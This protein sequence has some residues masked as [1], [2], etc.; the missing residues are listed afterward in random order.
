[1]PLFLR[2][3]E[4]SSLKGSPR[5]YWIFFLL[6][7]LL[8]SACSVKESERHHPS[9]INTTFDFKGKEFDRYVS[10]A[11][12][13]IE[14]SRT[15]FTPENREVIINGNAP[16]SLVPSKECKPGKDHPYTRGILLIHGLSDSPYSM[17]SLARFFKR[18]CFFVEVLLLP[19]H[20][21]R[22]GDL[23]DVTWEEWAKAVSFA[24]G[25]LEK[26]AERI[27]LGGLSTGAALSIHHAMKD[28][29]IEGLFLFSPAVKITPLARA[30]CWFAGL[31]RVIPS[32]RWIGKLQRDDNYF[33]YQSFSA[34]A[35]C[36]IFRL[37]K[38]IEKSLS[39]SPLEIPLFVAASADDST[40]KFEG[41]LELFKKALSSHKKMIVYGR[42]KKKLP[43]GAVLVE[44]ALPEKH[45][46]SSSHMAIVLPPE[47][48]FYG[49]NGEIL[50]CS[51]YYGKDDEAYRQCREKKEEFL[52]ETEKEFL[53]KGVVR[54]L[55]YNPFYGDMLSSLHNFIQS[56]P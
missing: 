40:V 18:Q 33:K 13:L 14:K 15:D 31:D 26:K 37:T 45:I 20:G 46:V 44:S 16:L 21:T 23:L 11:R 12:E 52:G 49:E 39:S 9:G 19:G 29:H 50:Y 22:P 48:P 6:L 30:T 42:E 3:K 34:N 25:T 47:D 1:M 36:Q 54:R 10:Y 17:K 35:A 55:T 28:P 24:V 4:E 7:L 32:L 43:E 27:F 38:E 5:R 53:Q 8:F 2:G 41:T 51:H 56:L